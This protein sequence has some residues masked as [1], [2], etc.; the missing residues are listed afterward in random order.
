MLDLGTYPMYALRHIMGTEPEECTACMIRRAPSPHELC[1]EV[2]EATFRFPSGKIGTAKM[3]MRAPITTFPTFDLTVSHNEMKVEDTNLPKD[4]AK[5]VTKT[6]YL[7]NFL[8]ASFWHRIEAVHEFCI[9]DETSG[10]LI[11]QWTTKETKKIY[12]FKDAGIERESQ[13]Y[14]TSYRHQL[15]QFVNQIRHRE[16]SGLWVSSDDSLAQAKMIDMA[17]RKSGLPLRRTSAFK[18]SNNL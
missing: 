12:T 11:K 7:C 6:L 1:D 2:A 14:W 13:P 15:E 4:Q 10:R 9:R 16:G 17:Y 18:L 5:F 3:D 8:R